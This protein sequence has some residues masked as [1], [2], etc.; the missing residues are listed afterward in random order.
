MKRV[1]VS[2]LLLIFALTFSVNTVPVSAQT[3]DVTIFP[4]QKLV[5]VDS[6]FLVKVDPK[7]TEKPIRI[8]WSVY[9]T[10]NEG[11]GSFP[12]V[13][14]KGLCYFSNEDGNATCGPSPFS[15]I[16][17]TEFYVHVITPTHITNKTVPVNV[18]SLA[19]PTS[20]VQRVDNTIYMYFYIEEKDLM[21]YTI[22]KEDLTIYQS[23]RPLEYDAADG[24]YEGNL[25]LNAGVYYF[26]FIVTDNLIHGTALKRIEIPSGDFLTVQTDKDEYWKG[27]EMKIT[28]TTNA[29]SVTGQVDFPNGTKAKDFSTNVKGDNTFSHEFSARSNWPEGEYEVKTSHPLVKSVKFSILE[30]FE[31]TPES[32]SGSVNKSGDFTTSVDVKNLRSNSTNISFSTSGGMKDE[33][34][35]IPDTQLSPQETVTISITITGVQTD[36]DGTITL[37]TPEGLQLGIPVSVTV[38]E[39]GPGPECPPPEKALEI[40]K[41]YL[42]WSQECVA[43]EEISYQLLIINNGDSALS[44]FEYDVEDTF[45]SDQS[46]E[47]LDSYGNIDVL[48]YDFSVDPGESEFLDIGITPESAGKH[49]GIITIKSGGDSAYLFVDLECFEDVSGD[50]ESLSSRLSDLNLGA[51]A[52]ED[53]NS[54]ISNV[55]DYFSLGNYKLASEYY[56]KAKAKIEVLEE[57][58]VSPPPMDFTWVI[59]VVVVIMV[60]LIAVWFFKFKK[61]Q[62]SEYEEE[63]EG[64]EGFE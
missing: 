26:A 44:S 57:G 9:D 60:V 1:W 29:Q 11:I 23:D 53:V 16:G 31:I 42:V 51:D 27:E 15:K 63:T 56:E 22:Y 4:M 48:V 2:V 3:P 25:T 62:I 7:T 55:Q 41:D 19:I 36:V 14:G 30:F 20:G 58:G 38:T 59:I 10:G 45:I 61:P 12:I 50:P 35:T 13:E 46:L 21:K 18:S 40:D 37:E 32:V 47:S 54:D 52:L 5:S 28:G 24:R 64:L 17:E 34:V 43:G 39:E 8:T 49:Q 33:Y 6:S